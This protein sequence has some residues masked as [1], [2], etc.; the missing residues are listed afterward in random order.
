MERKCC[1]LSLIHKYSQRLMSTIR[2]I[3]WIKHREGRL[4]NKNWGDSLGKVSLKYT[5][6]LLDICIYFGVLYHFQ[7]LHSTE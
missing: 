6:A 3:L 2:E 4:N 1:S 7:E 5:T